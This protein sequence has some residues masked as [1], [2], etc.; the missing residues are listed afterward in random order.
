M[1]DALE[2]LHSVSA[3]LAQHHLDHAR[4]AHLAVKVHCLSFTK[5]DQLRDGKRTADDGADGRRVLTDDRVLGERDGARALDPDV[6]LRP[7][8][9]LLLHFARHAALDADREQHELVLGDRFEKIGI[10]QCK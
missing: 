2:R 6:L 9:H 8:Q 3:H 5:D 10:C 1:L 7:Q 4:L